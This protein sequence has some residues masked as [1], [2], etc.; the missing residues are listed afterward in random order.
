MSTTVLKTTWTTYWAT[1]N[2]LPPSAKRNHLFKQRPNLVHTSFSHPALLPSS[3]FLDEV[4]PAAPRFCN[5]YFS[6]RVCWRHQY[7]K[8]G[9]EVLKMYA[10]IPSTEI[11]N[12]RMYQQPCAQVEHYRGSHFASPDDSVHAVY[13]AIGKMI[14]HT[15]I[16]QRPAANI[17]YWKPWFEEG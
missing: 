1:C 8:T 10:T 5:D 9:T 13:D 4:Y 17:A 3:I 12:T 16:R 11:W 15:K 14:E 6:A 2:I 7:K